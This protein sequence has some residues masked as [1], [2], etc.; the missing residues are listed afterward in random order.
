MPRITPCN[1]PQAISEPV[2]VSEPSI[3]SKPNALRVNSDIVSAC[4]R[5]SAMPTRDAAIA[6]K[7]CESAVRCGIAVI[8]TQIAK[9]APTS[10]PRI[11]PAMIHP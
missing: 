3:T 2:V 6:P 1:L 7:A 11:S 5:N 8:G 4:I 9:A 10:E